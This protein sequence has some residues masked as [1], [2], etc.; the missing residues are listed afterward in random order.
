MTGDLPAWIGPV[1][2]ATDLLLAGLVAIGVSRAARTAG[3]ETSERRRLV[4]WTVGALAGWFVVAVVVARAPF[5]PLHPVTLGAIVTPAVAG[6]ALVARSPT[7]RRVLGAVP[8]VW[9]VGGQFYRVIGV[10]FLA[11]WGAGALPAYFALPAGVGDIV[12]GVAAVGVA[13]LLVR[14]RVAA[15]AVLAWNAF[16]LLDLVVAVGAGS[17]LLAAP[18]VAVFGDGGVNTSVVVSFPLGLV[19]FFLV[20]VSVL[21]HVLSVATLVDRDGTA[22]GESASA[23]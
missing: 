5:G 4:G 15:R 12:T 8:Q 14:E 10:V 9:L 6:V 17:G 18:L 21:L 2:V 22:A 11:G 16:G 7:W 3:F 19:P 13:W 23:A 1:V 20:P